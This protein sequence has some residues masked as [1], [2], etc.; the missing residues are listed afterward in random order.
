[1]S[2]PLLAVRYPP[3]TK[4][5]ISFGIRIRFCGDLELRFYSFVL[6]VFFKVLPLVALTLNPYLVTDPSVTNRILAAP[7]DD[8]K[9][10]LV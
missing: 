10:L 6:N 7:P 1:M 8:I 9:V 4:I 3:Q 2:T 5:L